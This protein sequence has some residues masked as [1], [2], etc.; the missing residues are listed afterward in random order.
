MGLS[1]IIGISLTALI[2]GYPHFKGTDILWFIPLLCS[3]YLIASF[4]FW[5]IN[6]GKIKGMHAFYVNL[7]EY[8]KK[9]RLLCDGLI[10]SLI[11][12]MVSIIE[13]YLLS[14]AIGLTVPIIYFFIF[15]PVINALSAIPVT[16]AGLGIREMGFATLFNMFFIK[17]GVTTNQAVSLS[18]L[19]FTVMMMVNF[20]G[21]IEYVRIK[22]LPEKETRPND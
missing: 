7:A 22:K 8:K 20:I 10:L 9:K 4:L 1:A 13:V 15:V 16:I 2:G 11:V 5:R 19:T 21:G 12:Q 3:I 14:I 18:L 6:W 17:L